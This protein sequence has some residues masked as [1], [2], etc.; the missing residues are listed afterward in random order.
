MATDL[1]SAPALPSLSPLSPDEFAGLGMEQMAFVKQMS[2]G[3]QVWWAICAANGTPLA[4]AP[5]R[6]LAFAV[7]TQ[8]DMH[9]LSV[10]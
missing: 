3:D 6:D 4:V 7:V 5:S 2:R 8:Q 9:P 1:T 10:H